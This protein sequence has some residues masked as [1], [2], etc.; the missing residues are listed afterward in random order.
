[1]DMTPHIGVKG[2]CNVSHMLLDW[3]IMLL[4]WCIPNRS[5][6]K[7][8]SYLSHTHCQ[9][10]L[11]GVIER[12]TCALEFLMQYRT[13]IFISLVLASVLFM[14]DSTQAKMLGGRQDA[15]P[16]DPSNHKAALF[17]VDALNGGH[18]LR[19]NF[20]GAGKSSDQ[21]NACTHFGIKL[22]PRYPKPIYHFKNA[23]HGIVRFATQCR[24]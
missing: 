5:S 14:S 3:C 17:A 7:P 9:G 21:C 13:L 8:S 6:Q 23:L 1:M 4:D 16:A 20:V 15:D 12:K 22:S 24:V 11:R 19:Q 18:E 2:K 10:S